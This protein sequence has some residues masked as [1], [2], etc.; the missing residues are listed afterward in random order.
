MKKDKPVYLFILTPT[1]KSKYKSRNTD[2]I[3]RFILNITFFRN[4]FFPAT[5]IEWNKV[6]P[7][8]WSDAGLSVL[9]KTI[10]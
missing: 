8:F 2:K 7:N 9:K 3:T 1:K 6:D 10:C 5:V 4:S